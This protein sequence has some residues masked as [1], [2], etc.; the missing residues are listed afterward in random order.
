MDRKTP[1][2]VEALKS[3]FQDESGRIA[4]KQRIRKE[5][6]ISR[7]GSIGYFTDLLSFRCV[8][9]PYDPFLEDVY[10]FYVEF[11]PLDD[12]REQLDG[13][14]KILGLNRSIDYQNRLSPFRESWLM[15]CA[16]DGKMIGGVNFSLYTLPK[17]MTGKFGVSATL[18]VVYVFV[19]E[20]YRSIGIASLL[21]QKMEQYAQEWVFA[22][23]GVCKGL[24][25]TCEQ[26]AP[27]LMTAEAYW[28]DCVAA[29]IDQCDRL[30][31]WDRKGYK[32]LMMNYV[33]PS[34][35]EGGAPCAFMTLNVKTGGR[36]TVPGEILYEHIR[37]YFELSVF[38]GQSPEGDAYFCHLKKYLLGGVEVETTG[39]VEYYARL[40]E[41]YYS[42]TP[43]RR[44]ANLFNL[45]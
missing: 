31:W 12:E 10:D 28:E 45:P 7:Y 22:R 41:R 18:H 21:L 4:E 37:R 35:T 1:E 20:E 17:A 6:V 16:P 24:L 15:A 25:I 8:D 36:S 40:K 3:K 44:I 33:Q 19:R 11:F 9:D 42:S 13:L 5:K 34:L 2:S 23:R 43:V 26:N 30:A 32:R 39:D 14:R 38:K 29:G 27:E